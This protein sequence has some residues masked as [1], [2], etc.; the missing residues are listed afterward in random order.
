MHGPAAIERTLAAAHAAEAVYISSCWG[1]RIA[2]LRPSLQPDRRELITMCHVT[3]DSIEIWRAYIERF[4]DRPPQ[5]G[6][7]TSEGHDL[8]LGGRYADAMRRGIELDRLQ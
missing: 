8:E 5:L 1:S 7:F 6:P 2:G 3:R 4:T